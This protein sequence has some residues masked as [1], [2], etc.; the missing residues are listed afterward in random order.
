MDK[1]QFESLDQMADATASAFSQAAASTAFQLF[2]DERFRKLAGFNRLSQTEQD[3]IFNETRCCELV[4]IMLVFEAP[5]LRVA[6]STA[7]ISQG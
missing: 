7:T 5:D 4:L 6:V 1:T 3:R 2:K